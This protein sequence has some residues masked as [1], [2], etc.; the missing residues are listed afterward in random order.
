MKTMSY[1]CETHQRGF[2][3]RGEG[4][5]LVHRHCRQSASGGGALT[6]HR[7]EREVQKKWVSS[8]P[9]PWK[10]PPTW[11]SFGDDPIYRRSHIFIL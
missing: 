2:V 8:M 10:L 11:S 7:A 6:N 9:S 1:R 3:V 4:Q 5:K